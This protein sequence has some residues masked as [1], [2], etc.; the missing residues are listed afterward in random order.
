VSETLKR[1]SRSQD[2]A[3][4]LEFALVAPLLIALI[5]AIIMDS[6][7]FFG[8]QGLETAAESA[9]RMLMTG[10]AQ[11]TFTGNKV[12]GGVTITTKQQFRNAVCA[13]IPV[14]LSCSRLFVDVSTATNFSGANISGPTI[15]YDSSG[16]VS[17]NFSYAPGS[18]GSI[19]VVRL[20]YL[21]PTTRG[22]LGFNLANQPGGNMMLKATSVLKSEYY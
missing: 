13:S 9:A 17:N 5:I 14:F 16:N 20:F 6:L 3:A 18:A 22:P 7:A 8:Q 21:W 19:V 12:V 1:L 15:T 2:G 10:K 4:I 11:R